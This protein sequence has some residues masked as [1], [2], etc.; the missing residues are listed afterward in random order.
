M[1][2]SAM[3]TTRRRRRWPTTSQPRATGTGKGFRRHRRRCVP[4]ACRTDHQRALAHRRLGQQCRAQS[5]RRSTLTQRRRLVDHLRGQR[6]CDVPP[7]PRGSS[8]HDRRRSRRDRQHRFAVG[9]APGARAR[10]QRVQGSRRV[11]HAES[12]PR[13]RSLQC[14]RKR[15]VPGRDSHAHARIR[16]RPQKIDGGRPRQEG[17][18]LDASGVPR[19]WRHSSH[20]SPRT[21]HRSPR[22]RSPSFRSGKS[23]HRRMLPKRWRSSRP[24]EHGM[25]PEPPSTSPAPITFDEP[26]LWTD[27]RLVTSA[28]EL[29]VSTR[30]CHTRL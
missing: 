1:S 8:P 30:S 2:S 23:R 5:P 10:L 9:L 26:A 13:L 16:S 21:R 3:P 14:A 17:A 11:L 7:V 20:S 12:R 6:R 28:I 15:R 4:C 22:A 27:N 25:R 24:V 29:Q 19:K 18:L